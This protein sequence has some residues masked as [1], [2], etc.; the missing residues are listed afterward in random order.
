[1]RFVV[2]TN[3][4]VT[5]NGKCDH[6]G[7]ACQIACIE[8]LQSLVSGSKNKIILDIRG[9]IFN[10]YK[11][12]FSYR[13]QPGV[14]DFFFKHIHDHM[15]S[16]HNVECVTVTPNSDDMRGFDE[17]PV[18]DLDGS[19][20]KFLAAAISAGA[21]VANAVDTDWYCKRELVVSMNIE[22]HQL[23]PEHGCDAT[24]C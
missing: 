18:N 21:R 15:Y 3:V 8:F 20:R 13:G 11:Q 12:R 5:A 9:L 1:M 14:G 4:A 16:D 19:D 6:A 23:C 24:K 22:V 7:L 2:D 10:E 17:L